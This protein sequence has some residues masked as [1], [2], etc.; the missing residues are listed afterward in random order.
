MA[1]NKEITSKWGNGNSPFD[2][3]GTEGRQQRLLEEAERA[4]ARQAPT[5]QAAQIGTMQ[6]GQTS[7][8]RTDQ[9]AL[10]AQLQKMARGEDSVAGQAAQQAA[11]TGIANQQ[12][13]MQSG[14]GGAA[15]GRMAAQNAANITSGLA[16]TSAIARAQERQQAVGQLGG[17]LQGVRGQDENLSL[18]NAQIQNQRTMQQAGFNQQT[19]LANQQANLQQQQLNDQAWANAN[20]MEMNQALAN[21]QTAMQGYGADTQMSTVNQNTPSFWEKAGLGLISGGA[22]VGSAALLA[23]D[24]NLKENIQPVTDKDADELVKALKAYQYNYKPETGIQG[25]HTGVMAQDLEKS[26]VG[27]NAVIDT[28]DGKMVDYA[29]LLPALTALVTKQQEELNSL[30]KK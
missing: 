11:T 20:Q 10:I 3:Q 29:K 7:S 21:Q 1:Y 27:Q 9:A 24:R 6:E 18:A 14:R 15:A 26:K 5:S 4:K 2:A 22:S 16:G 13:L 8:A 17:V 23:S 25:T 19:G 30:K 12:A 28:P